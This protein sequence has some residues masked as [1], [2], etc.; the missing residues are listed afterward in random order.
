MQ[1][2]NLPQATTSQF[3][4]SARGQAAGAKRLPLK[5]RPCHF[6]RTSLKTG[7]AWSV[8][9]NASHHTCF[10][11]QTWPW[12][13]EDLQIAEG[14]RLVQQWNSGPERTLWCYELRIGPIPELALVG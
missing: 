8:N 1:A 9:F 6:V 4:G 7:T 13:R 5:E 11:E 2:H 12:S 14:A 10:A 3:I